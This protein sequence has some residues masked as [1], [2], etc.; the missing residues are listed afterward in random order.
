[1]R[2]SRLAL[3]VACLCTLAAAHA[4]ALDNPAARD[5]GVRSTPPGS[6]VLANLT[7]TQ[8]QLFVLGKAEFAEAEAVADGLGPAMN[9]DNCRGCHAYPAIGGSSPAENP[10]VGLARFTRGT[11][12][13]L[14]AFVSPSGPIR[15]ARFVKNADGTPDGGVHALLTIADRPDSSG[16]VLAAPD[17]DAQVADGNVSFRIPTPLFGAGLIEQIPDSAIIENQRANASSREALGI[18]GKPNRVRAGASSGEVAIGRFGWKAQNSS[19]LVAGAEAYNQEMGI[20][21][22]LFDVEHAASP[23]CPYVT[24]AKDAPDADAFWAIDVV[25]RYRNTMGHR[26][27]LDTSE[28]RIRRDAF[29]ARNPPGRY[30]VAYSNDAELIESASSVEKFAIFMRFLAPAAAAT[31]TPGGAQSIAKGKILF[32]EV[33]CAACHTPALR[34]GE[35]ADASLRDRAVDLYS[36]L[37]LHDMG[38]GLADGV[39]QFDAGPREFRTAPLWGVGQ[40]LFL[41]HDGRTSDLLV[42][43]RAHR[44]GSA[45]RGDASEANRV[46]DRFD[47]LSEVDKQHVLN[48]VRSL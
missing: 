7:P 22:E 39:T 18:A 35:A 48:F 27:P 28:L 44:S 19:L 36:D 9:L 30:D 2:G 5:P 41:L 14:P 3:A 4:P 11:P 17:F 8:A 10:Q 37:L 34:T 6:D 29:A 43:V 21:N 38:P 47:G 32:G 25:R 46:T 42:A 13:P 24:K 12:R 40:R 1:M 23:Q 16:C 45:A 26:Y 15:V 20:T 31:D 33:G